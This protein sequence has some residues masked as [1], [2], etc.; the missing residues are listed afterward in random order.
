MM[1]SKDEFSI[2]L[3]QSI[4]KRREEAGISLKQFEAMDKSF[5]RAMMSRIENGQETPTAY[6]V[7][8]I[9]SILEIKMSDIF[10]DY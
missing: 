6:T 4:R 1:I 7:Y 9:C 5:D 2:K 8:K 3:G 10:R